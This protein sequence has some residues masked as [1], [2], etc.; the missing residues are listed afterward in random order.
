MVQIAA[1]QMQTKLL[2]PEANLASVVRRL[3]E[4]ARLG[5]KIAV[6]PECVLTG[7]SLTAEEA[8]EIAE[9][10]PGPRLT[11]LTAECRERD[12]MAVVGTLELDEAG[13]VFNTAM[14]IGPDGLL[15]RFR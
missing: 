13:R 1:V 8:H 4:A 3:D 2:D 6:F 9:R 7:Y 10:I 11:R 15:G 5:A 14:L 12:M